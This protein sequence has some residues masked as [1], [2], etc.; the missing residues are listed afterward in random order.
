MTAPDGSANSR[1]SPEFPSAL[2]MRPFSTMA[3]AWRSGYALSTASVAAMMANPRGGMTSE[4][5][6]S[7]AVPS[8]SDQPARSIGTSLAL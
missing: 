8:A 4:G 1:R 2:P 6:T 3:D 7:I 5:R